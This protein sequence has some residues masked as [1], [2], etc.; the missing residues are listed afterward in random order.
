MRAVVAAKAGGIPALRE[1]ATTALRPGE[2]LVEIAGVGICHTDLTALAGYLPVPTPAVLG[3]EGA[4][5]VVAI[6]DEV[7]GLA[8]GDAV[9]LSFS[10]CGACP[11]CGKGR[12]AYCR[13]F[14]LLNYSGHRADGSTTLRDND[15]DVHGSWFGQSS[16]ATHAIADVRNAVKVDDDLPLHR[17]GPLGCGLLTGAGTVLNVLRPEPGQRLGFWGMGTVGLAGVMAARAAGVEEIVAV[18][19]HRDRLELA[20]ELG[21][22]H[23]FEPSDD[24]VGKI[25]KQVGGL[26]ATMEAVGSGAVIAQALG[27]LRSPGICATVG[28]QGPGNEITVDQ[29]HLLM[30]RTLSGVIE[31]DADPHTFI[32]RLVQMWRDG[33]FPFEKLVAEYRLDD[34]ATALDDF[35]AGRVVKPILVP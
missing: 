17:F 28:L 3:H 31:G 11:A 21:A 12:P 5:R 1:V 13:A 22:T 8:P 10:S 27:A 14:A 30:G 6:G 16:W 4:G 24:L 18:D 7:D 9:V 26:D 15:G 23:V 34:I 32:P 19:F 20:R 33:D 2:V 29:G 25:R 35:R